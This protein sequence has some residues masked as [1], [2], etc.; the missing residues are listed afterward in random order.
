M[1]FIRQSLRALYSNWLVQWL[2]NP[3]QING[4]SELF[5]GKIATGISIMNIKHLFM[6]VSAYCFLLFSSLEC[7]HLFAPCYIT[8]IQ[9]SI[10]QWLVSFYP[11]FCVN[12]RVLLKFRRTRNTEQHIRLL[13]I[14]KRSSNSSQLD[15]QHVACLEVGVTFVKR[16]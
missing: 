13:E 9:L 15:K 4:N 10:F 14:L 3:L 12:V 2:M 8:T 16:C 6:F 5:E 7:L 1:V 11:F